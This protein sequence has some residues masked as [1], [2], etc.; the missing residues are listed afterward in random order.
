MVRASK[1][2]KLEKS[3]TF[4]SIETLDGSVVLAEDRLHTANVRVKNGE[5]LF[6]VESSTL[7]RC[8]QLNP[9]LKRFEARVEATL[10]FKQQPTEIQGSGI[11]EA[12]MCLKILRD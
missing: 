1:Q 3:T 8:H 12:D 5:G 2:T 11:G 6:A 7:L 4:S 10:L 9:A